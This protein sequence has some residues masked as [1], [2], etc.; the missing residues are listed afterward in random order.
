MSINAEVLSALAGIDVPVTFQTYSGKSDPY[1][2]F[3]TYLDKPE[4]HADDQEIATGYYVQLDIWT[5]GDYTE[6][7][8]TVHDR[9]KRAGF[10]KI[11]FYDLYEKDTT[12]YHKVMRYVFEREES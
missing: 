9:M 8:K 1:I 11:N 10:R 12:V 5:K 6:L 2:T 7:V 4:Q 3:F